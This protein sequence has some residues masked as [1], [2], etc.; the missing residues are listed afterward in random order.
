MVVRFVIM[1]KLINVL[2]VISFGVSGA[3]VAGGVYVYANQDAI[4]ES[5]KE[6]VMEG[7]KEAIGG[8]EIGSALLS[9][10]TPEVDVTDEALG[11][12]SAI[13]IPVIPF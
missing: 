6:R 9:G 11:A 10:S 8:S 3:V 7:V 1:Q 5:I 4:K 12:D 2:A 13:P